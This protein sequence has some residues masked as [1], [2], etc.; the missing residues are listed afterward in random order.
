MTHTALHKQEDALHY[1]ERAR[2]GL[3]KEAS[4]FGHPEIDDY[5]RFKQGNFIVVTGHANVG[6][7]HIILYLMMLHTIKNGTTWL[8]YSSENEVGSLQRKLLEFKCGLPIR[9]IPESKFYDELAFVHGHFMFVDTNKLYD[10][11]DLLEVAKDIYLENPYQGFL[12]DPYNS[13]MI[14]QKRLGKVTTHEY[15]YEATSRIRLFC[16]SN[17]AMVVL[18]THP[19]TE[20]LRRIHPKGHEYEGHPI[21]PMASDVEGGGKFVNRADEFFVVHRYTQHEKDWIFTDIH[22]RKIK[23]IETGGRPTPLNA[24]I[25]LESIRNNIGFSTGMTNLMHPLKQAKENEPF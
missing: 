6:K 19:A 13:L 17:N 3:I 14:N 11:F 23:D 2:K 24:P 21:P 5:L 4:K 16:K 22:C 18:N 15:H 1:L 7:T 12:I 25:R 10:V 9:N 8:V 20:A